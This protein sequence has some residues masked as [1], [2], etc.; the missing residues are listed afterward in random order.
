MVAG[1]QLDQRPES[2]REVGNQGFDDARTRYGLDHTPH[3]HPES[4]LVHRLLVLLAMTV[5][6]LYR[7]RYLRGAAEPPAPSSSS[8]GLRLR[9]GPSAVDAIRSAL[10][11]RN[12]LPGRTPANL[13]NGWGKAPVF[14]PSE[15]RC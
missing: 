4:L 14:D 7:L 12:P 6:R 1:Q 3:H 8:C 15:G 11:P 10:P 13:R 5:E 9:P 2:G